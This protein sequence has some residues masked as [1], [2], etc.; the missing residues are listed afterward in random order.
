[1]A[2]SPTLLTLPFEIRQRILYYAICNPR[3]APNTPD[4]IFVSKL[5]TAKGLGKIPSDKHKVFYGTDIMS[6]IFVVCRLIHMELE[7]IL[8]TRFIF[9]FPHYTSLATVQEFTTTISPRACTLLR[10]IKAMIFFD[11]IVDKNP[12]QA[13]EAL[14]FLKRK[15]PGLK[16]VN[17]SVVFVGG[18]PAVDGVLVKKRVD[19]F[20]DMIMGVVISLALGIEVVIINGDSQQNRKDIMEVVNGKVEELMAS[21]RKKTLEDY[22]IR[23]LRDWK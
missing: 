10:E 15:L 17:L 8:F 7:E 21:S 4:S 9:S 19:G 18:T 2:Q 12:S 16:R 3:I 20:A 22:N 13:Q 1:M 6:S 5:R 23:V 14:I 11:L